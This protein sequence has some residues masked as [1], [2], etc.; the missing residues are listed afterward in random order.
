MYIPHIPICFTIFDR[1]YRKTFWE[2]PD[3]AE[4]V[5]LSKIRLYLRFGILDK[6]NKSLIPDIIKKDIKRFNLGSKKTFDDF[7]NY[8]VNI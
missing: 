7:I 1:S 5:E 3:Q 6:K 4:I 2:H 8:C